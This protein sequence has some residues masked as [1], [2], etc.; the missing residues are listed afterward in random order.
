VFKNGDEL[1]KINLLLGALVSAIST[2]NMT[3]RP[4]F[5]IGNNVGQTYS[6]LSVIKDT[7]L[8]WYA[9]LLK[10]KSSVCENRTEY[11]IYSLFPYRISF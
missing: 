3:P 4:G 6:Y 8:A 10:N 7:V 1:I 9:T 2:V 5:I 11:S